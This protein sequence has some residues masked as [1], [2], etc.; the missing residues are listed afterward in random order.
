MQAA[1]VLVAAIWVTSVAVATPTLLYSTTVLY[2]QEALH[3][4]ARCDIVERDT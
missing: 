3:G 1:A 2:S 4:G